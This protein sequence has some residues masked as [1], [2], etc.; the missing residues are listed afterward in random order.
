[1]A[2]TE[3]DWLEG[4]DARTQ[5]EREQEFYN[6]GEGWMHD[7]DAKAHPVWWPMG[8]ACLYCGRGLDESERS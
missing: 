6:E 1:M 3:R 4:N 7:C 5:Y 2:E 8:T